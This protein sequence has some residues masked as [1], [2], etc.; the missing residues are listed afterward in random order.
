MEL[1]I[2]LAVAL[3]IVSVVALVVQKTQ[4]VLPG[5]DDPK[6]RA[7]ELFRMV[8]DEVGGLSVV[9]TDDGWPRLRGIVDGLDVEVDYDNHLGQG[10]EAMLGMRCRIPEAETSPPTAVWVGSVDVLHTHYGRPR[11][12]GDVDGLFEVYT[13]REPTAS[14][15]W[16]DKELYEVLAS[17]PGA[18][19]ILEEGQLT[20]VFADL[21]AESVRTALTVPTLI[22]RGVRQVTLH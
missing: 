13:R 9:K 16:Q 14:E 21:D 18:G 11:P 19:V 20:V 17:L 8:A 3:A 10:L 12:A 15:W 22:R 6:A 5:A 1:L 4:P 7:W 2:A